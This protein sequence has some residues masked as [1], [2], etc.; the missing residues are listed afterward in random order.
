M[1]SHHG[2]R[3]LH[4]RLH[5]RWRWYWHLMHHWHLSWGGISKHGFW[6]ANNLSAAD[7]CR[8]PLTSFLNAYE[9]DTALITPK[10]EKV[11]YNN[12]SSTSESKF[13]MNTLAP[14]SS[15]ICIIFSKKF[16]KTI[17]LIFKIACNDRQNYKNSNVIEHI[18]LKTDK[19]KI[20]TLMLLYRPSVTVCY[21]VV[22]FI[23]NTITVQVLVKG[24]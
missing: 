1:L 24:K 19:T 11:S 8:S 6:A 13:P 21:S 5:D 7:P 3:Y 23:D 10:A 12:F 18:K 16:N 22:L 9:I 17:T 14:T 2:H 4:R 15:I 20:Y